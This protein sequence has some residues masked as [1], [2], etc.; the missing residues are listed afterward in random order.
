MSYWTHLD[1]PECTVDMDAYDGVICPNSVQVRR[2]AFYGYT[3]MHFNL[4][5]LKIA[6]WD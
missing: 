4:A 6:R 2:I 1:Q 3:E 5:N